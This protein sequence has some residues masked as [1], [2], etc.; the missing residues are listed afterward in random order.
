MRRVD[1]LDVAVVG[2]GPAGAT[3]ARLLAARGAHVTLFEARRLPRPKLCGGGLT[4]KALPYLAGDAA[5][6]I[7]RRVDRVELAGGRAPAVHFGLPDAEVAFVER[8]PFDLRLVEAAAAAGVDVRDEWP[9]QDVI[10]DEDGAWLQGNRDRHRASVVVAADGE[11]SRI[12]RRLGI[13]GE[14]HRLSLALEVDLPFAPDRSPRELQLRFGGRGGYAWYFPKA[15]HA[16]VGILSWR[17]SE[18]AGLREALRAYIRELGLPARDARILGH[19]IPQGMRRA[20]AVQGRVLLVGDAAAVAEPL[21]GEGISYAMA[22]A[23]LAARTIDDWASDRIR[24]LDPYDRRLRAAIGPVLRRG[25]LVADIAD[26]SATLAVLGFRFNPWIRT[27]AVR[28]VAGDGRP[29][30]LPIPSLPSPVTRARPTE[31]IPD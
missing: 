2:A 13:G 4:P 1:R 8:A 26:R 27:H 21:F 19:W 29:Y 6:A 25:Q 28:A 20:S 30:A 5:S 3:A 10:P 9:V 22:S 23:A 15:D 17:R 11:P 16:N 18:Q 12:A 7:V 31:V 14:A 24:T